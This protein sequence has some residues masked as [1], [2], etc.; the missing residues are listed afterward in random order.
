MTII[1]DTGKCYLIMFTKPRHVQMRQ[2]NI[3]GTT[4]FSAQCEDGSMAAV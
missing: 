3:Q 1:Q 2:G 4:L